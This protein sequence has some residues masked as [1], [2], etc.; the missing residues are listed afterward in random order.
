MAF[1]FFIITGITTLQVAAK[2]CDVFGGGD[3][4]EDVSVPTSRGLLVEE[5]SLFT[6]VSLRSQLAAQ[7]HG[8]SMAW[9][10][11]ARELLPSTHH[12]SPYPDLSSEPDSETSDV[13]RHNQQK[14]RSS[15]PPGACTCQT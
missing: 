12:L 7:G 15:R 14:W 13:R 10:E 8:A 3:K 9:C 2:P 11:P 6:C 1:I 5:M 4:W